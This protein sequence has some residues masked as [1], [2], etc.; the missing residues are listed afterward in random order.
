MNL[1]NKIINDL[2][3]DTEIRKLLPELLFRTNNQENGVTHISDTTI[4]ELSSGQK[5]ILQT[6][7]YVISNAVERSLI[8]ID[9]PSPSFENWLHQRI[10][11]DIESN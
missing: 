5:I 6:F 1:W 4:N 9:E 2:S 3:F 7:A 11:I 8:I 10:S